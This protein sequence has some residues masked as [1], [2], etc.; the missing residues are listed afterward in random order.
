MY[1]VEISEFFEST[2]LANF[3]NNSEGNK[4]EK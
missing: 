3:K 4:L 1:V 2:M